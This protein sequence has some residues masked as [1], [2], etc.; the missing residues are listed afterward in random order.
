M[1]LVGRWV[2]R[3]AETL[4]MK[5]TDALN[6]KFIGITTTCFGQP[7]HPSSGVL[8][9]VSALVHFMQFWWPFATSSILLLVANGHQNYIK[10]TNADARLRTP[11]DGRKGCPKH[12]VVIPINLEFSASVGF[13]YKEFVT[14]HGHL[15]LKKSMQKHFIGTV[16]IQKVEGACTSELLVA[17]YWRH[18]N[19]YQ[20]IA[21]LISVAQPMRQRPTEEAV[22]YQPEPHWRPYVCGLEYLKMG[23][24]FRTGC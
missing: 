17:I 2:H 12:V 10:C 14:M 22:K 3:Y 1:W 21:V 16:S 19:T 18:A 6:F 9:R 24:S 7:F 8:S 4:W 15:I 20:N 23:N 13:I 11:D 5:P